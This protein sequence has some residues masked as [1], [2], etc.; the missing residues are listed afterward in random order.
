[1][2]KLFFVILFPS[3]IFSQLN[4]NAFED[5]NCK[6]ACE[7]VNYAE[8]YQGLKESQELFDKAI[9]LCPNMDYAYREKSVPYVKN[10][11]FMT[12]KKLIDKAV[13]INP[14]DNLGYRGWCKYQFL[15]NYRD[16][17]V[18]L[19]NLKKI[20][21]TYIRYSQ[22]GDYNLNIV[23]ALCY[24]GLGEKY[25]AIQMI[26]KLLAEKDYVLM[27]YDY[28]HLGVLYL[29]TGNFEN[30]IKCFTKENEIASY[31]ETYYYLA[32][33]HKYLHNKKLYL[34]NLLK[35]K[36]LYLQDFRMKDIYTHP[37]DAI[38]LNQIIEKLNETSIL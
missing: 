18:D 31:A 15:R 34:K 10:G 17:L 19:E 21:S 37:M 23:I 25:K 11:D 27:N 38:Y 9:R 6:K 28:I 36:E 2:K 8:N 32:M 33:A 14:T 35:A 5:S 16:A 12:W 3:H 30:A 7:L 1:M 20:D 22:N 13:E 24:K 26:K 29:E 4:C